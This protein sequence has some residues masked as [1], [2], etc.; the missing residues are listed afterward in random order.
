MSP[1]LKR[2]VGE[3]L[4]QA[5]RL[6][7]VTTGL[8]SSSEDDLSRAHHLSSADVNTDKL[9][10]PLHSQTWDEGGTSSGRRMGIGVEDPESQ[11][12]LAADRWGRTTGMVLEP[13][14]WDGR[15]KGKGKGRARDSD[16]EALPP[17]RGAWEE[18]DRARAIEEEEGGQG[19]QGV[20][21]G[22]RY[23][24]IREDDGPDISSRRGQMEF[25]ETEHGVKHLS[26]LMDLRNLLLEVS[27]CRH[28]LSAH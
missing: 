5:R 27:S 6:A 15:S 13:N 19:E 3:Q 8:I 20:I 17:R 23:K 26:P 21:L 2:D 28:V 18:L 14:R 7:S 22:Q 25:E 9:K 1:I 11:R 16:E 10:T 4:R 24:G 12:A